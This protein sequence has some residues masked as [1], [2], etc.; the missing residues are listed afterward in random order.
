VTGQRFNVLA[1]EDGMS[2]SWTH[3]RLDRRS[4][5]YWRVTFDHRPINTITAT[6]IV[7]L[8][9]LID[10][11]ERDMQLNV[12]VFDSAISSSPTTT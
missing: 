10:L 11:I 6:T 2:S 5:A 4:P 1:E 12:V 7:E 8:S 9:Q 3:F